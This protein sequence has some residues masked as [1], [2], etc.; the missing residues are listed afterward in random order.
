MSNNLQ[1]FFQDLQQRGIVANVANL[2]NFYQLEFEPKKKVVYLGIDCTGERLHIGHLFLLIQTIRFAK[3][4]FQ[5]LLVLGGA[6]SKIGDPSDKNEERP[7]L[8]VEKVENYQAKIKAQIER[9]LI[10]PKKREK[11][12]LAP[13]EQFY[14]DNPKLLNDIYQILNVN[15][16]TN[17]DQQ[18]EDYLCYI[19][20]LKE[21]NRF[22]ILNNK[23]WLE[24]M[25]FIDFLRQTGKYLTIAY[26]S[27]KETVKKRINTGLSFLEFSYPLI[28]AYDFYYLYKNY[29][30]HGQLGGSDQWGNLT[31]GLKLIKSFSPENKTFAF[32][33]PLL[34]DSSGKKISKSE[35]GKQALW[36]DSEHKVFFDFFRNMPDEQAKIYIKQFTFLSESQINELAKLNKPPSRRIFQRILYE[37]LLFINN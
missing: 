33:F 1:L 18:W 36:L 28:Q 21:N 17:K 24:K 20:P 23:D 25:N 34:A 13:L 31:T 19:W 11:N 22:L 30:C 32:N 2:D 27:S 37:F 15:P 8:A 9:I 10:K 5:I 16:T 26:L 6:T 14:A 7:L 12:D 4:G 3:E 35:S 29:N